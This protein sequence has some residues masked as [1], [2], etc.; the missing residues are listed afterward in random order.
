MIYLGLDLSLNSTGYALADS[1]SKTFTVGR[2][3]P[4]DYQPSC[5]RNKFLNMSEDASG[6][7]NA[8]VRLL[9]PYR[10]EQIQVAIEEVAFGFMFKRGSTNSTYQLLFE[11]ATVACMLRHVFGADIVF[12]NPT[13][14]KKCFTGNGKA[15]KMLSINTMLQY[16]PNMWRV[17][18]K[19]D[20]IA[21]ALSVLSMQIPIKEYACRLNMQTG[22]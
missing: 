5:A 6:I 10:F 19:V 22:M 2:I 15:D 17:A 8:L 14:H 3:R 13:Q 16:W 21:D 9:M 20:D 18:E 11:G 7:A 4:G 1:E 12:V